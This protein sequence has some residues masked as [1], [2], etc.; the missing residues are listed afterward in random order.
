MGR[1]GFQSREHVPGEPGTGWQLAVI[2]VVVFVC[3]LFY[4][5]WL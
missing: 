5:G 1:G 2:A 3:T 4:V